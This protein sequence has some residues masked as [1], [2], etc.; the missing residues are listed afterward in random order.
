MAQTKNLD[1]ERVLLHAQIRNIE[2]V[3]DEFSNDIINLTN[4]NT[5]LKDE[6][7]LLQGQLILKAN[8][9]PEKLEVV[10]DE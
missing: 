7:I 5:R 4:E 2:N 9:N 10:S 8:L 3:M 1:S 6:I